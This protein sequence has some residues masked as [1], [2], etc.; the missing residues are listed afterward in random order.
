MRGGAASWW[1]EPTGVPLMHTA[2]RISRW[3]AK[4]KQAYGPCGCALRKCV[5]SLL[6]RVDS[7]GG[8]RQLAMCAVLL[9]AKQRVIKVR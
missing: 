1:G 4:S 6:V 5:L 3:S 8:P 7:V 9:L 2:A